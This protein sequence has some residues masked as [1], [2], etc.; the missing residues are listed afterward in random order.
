MILIIVASLRKFLG[1]PEKEY[2]EKEYVMYRCP[3]KDHPD[4]K[5]SFRV[6]KTG[7]NCYGCGK[8]GNYWQFLKD[9]NGWDDNQVKHY[10]KSARTA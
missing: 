7:Y 1:E 4:N 5:P 10:L 2:P 3:F 6:H 8:S 9:Y